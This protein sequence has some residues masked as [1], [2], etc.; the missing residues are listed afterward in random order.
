MRALSII[1]QKLQAKVE[2]HVLARPRLPIIATPTNFRPT[3]DLTMI[4]N[5]VKFHCDIFKTLGGDTSKN[6]YKVITAEK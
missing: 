6:I 2:Y 5:Y 1:D 3:L 4:Y